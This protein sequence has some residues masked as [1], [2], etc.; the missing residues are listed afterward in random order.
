M[1]NAEYFHRQAMKLQKL[2]ESIA[3][4]ARAQSISAMAA[5]FHARAEELQREAGAQVYFPKSGSSDG[6]MDRD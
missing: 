5:D 2:A 4:P 6:E 3:D 1:I